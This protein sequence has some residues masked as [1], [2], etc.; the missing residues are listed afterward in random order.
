[1]KIGLVCQNYP[2]AIFEGGISHYS[3]MLAEGLGQRG[4]EVY[5]LTSTEFSLPISHGGDSGK[6]T[7]IPVPGPWSMRT[8]KEIQAQSRGRG[9]EALILQ[10][11]PA[12]FSRS[13]RIAWALT[14]FSCQK[15]TAFHTLWGAG[16]DRLWGI[17]TLRGSHKII[18]TNS[19]V[20]FLLE[21]HLPNFL[22][23]TYWIP[24]GSNILPP[25][26]VKEAPEKPSSKNIISYFGMIYPGKGLD[27]ILDCLRELKGRGCSFCFKFIGG[28]MLAHEGYEADFRKKIKERGL[29]TEV[30][31][32]GLVPDETVS[33]W[34]SQ[35][36]FVFLPYEQGL[37]DRRGTLMAAI[38]HG[39]A[40]MTAPPAVEMPYFKNGF[41]M[42]WPKANAVQD[43]LPLLERL[44]RDDCWVVS[45]ESGAR[46][47]TSWFSW[48]QI[49]ADHELV[50][51][52][53]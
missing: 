46:Q 30:E 49:L 38:A 21:R 13:F 12:S 40:I 20:M 39:K 22:S 11:S 42:V 25:A 37:S 52:Y 23:K 36:R 28:G 34:L 7:V 45:L 24:I 4:H 2:P 14:P 29:E 18:A 35:S 1:M 31:H 10:F 27:L 44:L 15:I 32:L 48:G 26:P 41:N 3:R 19:E 43:Y 9:L 5:A 6:V 33:H 47:L 8:L 51:Q 53:G 16:L 50:L 17:L